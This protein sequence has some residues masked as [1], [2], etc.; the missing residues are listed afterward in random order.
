MYW[1]CHDTYHD[2]SVTVARLETPEMP[3]E[4]HLHSCLKFIGGFPH[5]MS[6]NCWDASQSRKWLV[7]QNWFV[8]QQNWCCCRHNS[9]PAPGSSYKDP[10]LLHLNASS[11]SSNLEWCNTVKL[12]LDSLIQN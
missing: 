3:C 7:S 4:Q 5:K 1:K 9:Q 2:I 8:V 6:G 11:Y 10:P 12:V